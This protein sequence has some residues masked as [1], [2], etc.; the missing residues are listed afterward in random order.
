ML[1]NF[2]P[3]Q[4]ILLDD[5]IF[6][7]TAFLLREMPSKFN[8][9]STIDSLAIFG[10]MDTYRLKEPTVGFE[11]GQEFYGP[12]IFHRTVNGVYMVDESPDRPGHPSFLYDGEKGLLIPFVNWQQYEYAPL[13]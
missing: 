9:R 3:L 12:R 2:R 11:D 8:S 4:D 1:G 13:G 10:D 5:T 6:R 7:G